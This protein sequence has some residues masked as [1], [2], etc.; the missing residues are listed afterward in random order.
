MLFRSQAD[1]QINTELRHKHEAAI[2]QQQQPAELHGRKGDE[3][4]DDVDDQQSSRI[5]NNDNDNDD[6]YIEDEDNDD[7]PMRLIEQ[8]ASNV[9]LICAELIDFWRLMKEHRWNN[10]IKA[11]YMLYPN[12]Y[13]KQT[14][15]QLR[16]YA[17]PSFP[18]C[19]QLLQPDDE[20]N[21]RHHTATFHGQRKMIF[22]S[23]WKQYLDECA[24]SANMILDA[25]QQQYQ[26]QQSTNC[27]TKLVVGTVQEM[28][29][30]LTKEDM[31]HR[32]MTNFEFKYW[33]VGEPT[34]EL[35]ITS[36]K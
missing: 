13:P 9:W 8:V 35:V 36:S 17:H 11:H 21:D 27:S 31:E 3:R 23:N 25:Q 1:F 29:Y 14:R 30:P 18:L 16:W 34:Y 2:A 24:V 28:K 12:P 20:H 19:L 22:R 5:N 15:L 7:D 26:Q 33:M 4:R 10:Y 32:A 6:N